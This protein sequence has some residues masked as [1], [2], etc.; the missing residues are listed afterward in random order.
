ME[1][2]N[3]VNSGDMVRSKTYKLDKSVQPSDWIVAK[4]SRKKN[5]VHCDD[6]LKDILVIFNV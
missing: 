4:Y 6:I 1:F 2:L 5:F 3:S